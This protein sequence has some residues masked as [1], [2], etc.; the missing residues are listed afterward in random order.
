MGRAEVSALRAAAYEAENQQPLLSANSDTA[1][2][3]GKVVQK[4]GLDVVPEQRD[5]CNISEPI[6]S[7]VR[8]S[9]DLET[10]R[11]AGAR[12]KLFR[13]ENWCVSKPEKPSGAGQYLPSQHPL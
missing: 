5:V 3:H 7:D 6:R 11:G 13:P 10:G 1:H 4:L 12:V 2:A 8:D 9:L